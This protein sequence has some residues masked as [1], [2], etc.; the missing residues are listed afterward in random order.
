MYRSLPD[1]EI[2]Q[3]HDRVI[4]SI[5]SKFIDITIR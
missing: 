4:Q 3:I 1:T 2:N 5:L